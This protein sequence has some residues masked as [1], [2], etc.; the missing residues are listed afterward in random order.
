[1]A[2]KRKKT[3]NPHPVL[4]LPTVK[5]AVAIVSEVLV[6]FG[7]GYCAEAAR[8]TSSPVPPS[9]AQPPLVAPFPVPAFVPLDIYKGPEVL[10]KFEILLLA[11]TVK[12]RS[13]IDWFT[14]GASDRR[15]ICKM[16]F[17]HGMYARQ[18]V[19]GDHKTA[20]D[21]PTLKKSFDMVHKYCPSTGGGGPVCEFDL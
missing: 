9:Q 17:L 7:A 10:Q 1:M 8:E 16:A 12:N 2:K 14:P 4:L 20:I 3:G 15:T 6:H 5:K 21:F 19:V 13:Q 11:S 18:I